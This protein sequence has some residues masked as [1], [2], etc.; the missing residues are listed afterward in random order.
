MLVSLLM[1]S[2]AL[3]SSP[4]P[5]APPVEVPPLDPIAQEDPFGDLIPPGEVISR[6]VGVTILSELGSDLVPAGACSFVI[7]ALTR[8][9]GGSVTFGG[10]VA[11]SD[12][13]TEA[14][15]GTGPGLRRLAVVRQPISYAGETAQA[16]S[17]SLPYADIMLGL[18][19]G[20]GSISVL[21]TV[22]GE[23]QPGFIIKNTSKKR[24]SCKVTLIDPPQD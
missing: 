13:G 9:D 12:R 15:V 5:P 24:D 18:I 22:D 3:A 11:P 21:L 17:A 4:T 20:V 23:A 14:G 16:T 2:L 19:D 8:E 1:A 10:V 6:R 7:H